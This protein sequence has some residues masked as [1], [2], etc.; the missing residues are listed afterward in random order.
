MAGVSHLVVMMSNDLLV[1]G[2]PSQIKVFE[3]EEH[4]KSR[5]RIFLRRLFEAD[6]NVREILIGA[7]PAKSAKNDLVQLLQDQIK[8]EDTHLLNELLD[9]LLDELEQ[10]RSSEPSLY[11]VDTKTGKTLLRLDTEAIYQPPDYIGEDGLKHRAKPILHPGISVPLTLAVHE[12]AKLQ[13]ALAKPGYQSALQYSTAPESIIQNAK[14]KLEKAGYT[15][16]SVDGNQVETVEI[17]REYYDPLQSTGTTF[18]RH[19]LFG[20]ILA[21]RIIEKIG[22]PQLCEILDITA[23]KNSKQRWYTVRFKH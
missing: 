14:S 5:L 11:L 20:A 7:K 13:K 16:G 2:I 15:V 8:E 1:K 18:H 9:E 3:P 17:G 10:Q 23:E 6:L 12:K 21:K 19:E 22:T 4:S